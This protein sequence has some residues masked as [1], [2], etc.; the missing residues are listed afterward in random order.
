MAALAYKI[1][2]PDSLRWTG[3]IA[4]PA[5]LF[6]A[7]CLISKRLHDRG[8]RGWWGFLVV[9]ALFPG[10]APPHGPD[11]FAALVI[12]VVAAIDLGMMPGQAHGNRFGPGAP[13]AA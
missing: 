2:V 9:W 12:L 5:L 8:R 4:Y 7:A 13:Q 3:W 1:A 10:W 11:Q 6:P